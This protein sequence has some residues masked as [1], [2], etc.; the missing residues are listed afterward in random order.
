MKEIKLD[1]GG[2]IKFTFQG[3]PYIVRKPK[4]IEAR[5][6]QKQM[7]GSDEDDSYTALACFLDK[8]GLPHKVCNEL[9]V[10]QMQVVVE[11]LMPEKKS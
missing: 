10:D 11:A 8:L 7:N 9:N 5:D 2:R 1:D 3:A 6:F 4:M